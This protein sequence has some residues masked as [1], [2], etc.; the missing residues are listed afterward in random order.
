MRFTRPLGLAFAGCALLAGCGRSPV[1]TDSPPVLLAAEAR[2]PVR[3][4]LMAVGDLG[5]PP[6]WPPAGFTPL[7]LARLGANA[8]DPQ[9]AA[10]LGP[11]LGKT[12]LNPET[13]L[14]GT[15]RDD[16]GR[17]LDALFGTPAAPT[18]LVPGRDPAP[19]LR[20]QEEFAAALGF[21][22]AAAAA[23]AAARERLGAEEVDEGTAAKVLLHLDDAALAR[24]G[25]LYRRWC[26]QCH[27]PAG[28]GDGAHA[29]RTGAMPRDYRRGLFKFVTCFPA[30]TPRQ[31]ELG[32]ARRDDLKRTVRT[33]LDGSMMPPFP[34]FSDPELDDLVG[35]VMHLSVRG[36]AEFEAVARVI[37]LMTKPR[38]DDPEYSRGFVEQVIGEKLLATLGNW[39]RAEDSPIPIPPENTPAEGDRLVSAV[40]G[41]RAF[42]GTCAGCH[43]DFGRA[44]QLKFDLWGTVVQP[45]NLVLGVYRGG[46]RGE[47]LYARVYGGI[48]ASTMPDSKAMAGTARPGEPDGIWDVVHFLQMLGD[49]RGRKTLTRFDPSVKLEP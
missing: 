12:I 35:Y 13:G 3:T 34:Q 33:G 28:G 17:I 29:I 44:E 40:R 42:L 39:K 25:V 15:Q 24:G 43:Q 1:P 22:P 30:S 14:T 2:Y 26:L 31:G 18:V 41:Y 48:Y 49:P 19:L 27:G 6:G 21:A 5:A 47:D 11:K 16:I 8:P 46:R 7:R 4:D 20:H 38:D 37:Q 36:E 10:L 32:K 45:R 9:F 23:L